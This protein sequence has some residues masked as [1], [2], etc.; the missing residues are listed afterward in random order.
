MLFDIQN[1]LEIFH[2]AKTILKTCS[3]YFH[4]FQTLSASSGNYF[5]KQYFFLGSCILTVAELLTLATKMCSQFHLQT[6]VIL[7]CFRSSMIHQQVVTTRITIMLWCFFALQSVSL[8]VNLLLVQNWDM[9]SNYFP[10]PVC[11]GLI[12]I[13]IWPWIFTSQCTLTYLWSH[14]RIDYS[15]KNQI[16]KKIS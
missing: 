2:S 15:I 13:A 5:L 7:M 10:R 9:P 1:R 14:V 4:A 16:L 6:T 8:H 12:C 11:Y 3:N